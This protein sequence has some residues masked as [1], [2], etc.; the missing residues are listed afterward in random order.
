[1]TLTE[2]ISNIGGIS[3]VIITVF[4]YINKFFNQYSILS[5]SKEFFYSFS[6]IINENSKQKKEIKLNNLKTQNFDKSKSISS[7]KE[8]S[9]KKENQ[10]LEK[11]N[12]YST[13][14]EP[15]KSRIEVQNENINDITVIDENYNKFDYSDI[16]I[17]KENKDSEINKKDD[18]NFCKYF[19]YKISFGKIYNKFKVIEDFR[20]KLIS[21]EN[22]FNNYLNLHNLIKL[23]NLK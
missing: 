21:V 19:I 14:N 8:S 3:N 15:E 2:M 9:T 5:D 12:N 4:Y 6:K 10:N 22:I 13:I 17:N 1:M 20:I 18:L 11:N 23:I 16:F 7:I